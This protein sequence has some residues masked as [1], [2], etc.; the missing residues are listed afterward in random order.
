MMVML[1]WMPSHKGSV[2]GSQRS[3]IL[4][5]LESASMCIVLPPSWRNC[6]VIGLADNNRTMVNVVTRNG[7][8]LAKL[9]LFCDGS[10]QQMS[11]SGSNDSTNDNVQQALQAIGQ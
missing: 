6:E 10:L 5:M 7:H 2:I 9:I 4:F 3:G 8:I 11:G 1:Y